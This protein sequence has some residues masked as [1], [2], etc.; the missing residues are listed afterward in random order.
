MQRPGAGALIT[1]L[2]AVAFLGAWAVWQPLRSADAVSASLDAVAAGHSGQAFTDARDAANI[3]PLTIE[4]LQILSELH[5]TR[6]AGAARQELVQATQRQPDN[7]E[8]WSWL[9]QFDLARHHNRLAYG[10]L[11]R[12]LRLDRA[13]SALAGTV[14]SLRS[15]LGIPQPRP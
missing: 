9:G 14:A 8:P 7:P 6:N 4:P 15:A 2:V 13:N 12:E 3:D 11:E 1:G 10:S 5:G